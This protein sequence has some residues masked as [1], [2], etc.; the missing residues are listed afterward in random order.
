MWLFY[1]DNAGVL[2]ATQGAID[3]EIMTSVAL[4]YWNGTEGLLQEERHGTVMDFS[5]HEWIHETFGASYISGLAISGYIL[6]TDND[7]AVSIGISDG[8]IHDEDTKI[9]IVHSATPSDF[10]EQILADPAQIPVLHIDGTTFKRD[11]A[12]NFPFK[13]TSAGRVNYNLLSGTWGQQEA[14]DN[15]Y[16]AVFVCATTVVDSPIIVFQGQR[17]DSSISDSRINNQFSNLVFPDLP[18]NEITPLY[19]IILNTK[20][21]FGDTRKAEIVEVLDLRGLRVSAGTAVN[22]TNHNGLTDVQGG[23]ATEYFHF[24]STEHTRLIVGQTTKSASSALAAN[25]IDHS[26]DGIKTKTI[27]G[28]TVFT[29]ISPILDKVVALRVTGDFTVSFPAT[30]RNRSE[31]EN[32]YDGTK[33]N[34]IM[35]YCVDSGTPEYWG[36]IIVGDT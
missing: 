30:V 33:A 22:P 15:Y 7:S 19:R 17:E 20:N 27:A 1:Y 32:G 14:T 21:T 6:D 28:N 16:V 31:L 36:S 5:T 34:L 12:T 11:A 24:T 35:L 29:I 25:E 13:N 3:Y 10:F 8:V 4:V 9:N 23:T 26:S 18:I 2:Q